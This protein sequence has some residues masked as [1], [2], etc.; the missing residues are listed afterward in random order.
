MLKMHRFRWTPWLI[1]LVFFLVVQ[2]IALMFAPSG[3][4]IIEDH[5]SWMGE[6]GLSYRWMVNYGWIGFGILILLVVGWFK[7]KEEIPSSLLLPMMVFGIALML[8][9][10][11]NVDSNDEVLTEY[12]FYA[13][14]IAQG[15]IVLSALLHVFLVKIERLRVLNLS[16]ALV[17]LISALL[18][19]LIPTMAGFMERLFWIMFIIWLTTVYGRL[20]FHNDKR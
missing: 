3:Y 6:Q 4:S 20:D 5:I 18:S 7:Q 2:V 13:F 10:L 17:L 11:W 9:G 8:M 14:Y 19:L 1:P 12:H 16:F 15:A